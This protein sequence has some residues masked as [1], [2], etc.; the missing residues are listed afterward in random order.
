MLAPVASAEF[1]AGLRRNLA[2]QKT[3][4]AKSRRT[5]LAKLERIDSVRPDQSSGD[6]RLR[7]IERAGNHVLMVEKTD[8]GYPGKLL[9]RD[10]S[11]TLRR[12]TDA[13]LRRARLNHGAGSGLTESKHGE[14]NDERPT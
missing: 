3:K 9:A 1:C 12:G 2:G 6:F 4:Q 10:I 11:F 8:I 5:M 7:S 14:A 13:R